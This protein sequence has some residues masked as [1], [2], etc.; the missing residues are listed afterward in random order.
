MAGKRLEGSPSKIIV[1][2]T[3][4]AV[5]GSVNY[6]VLLIVLLFLWP[7]LPPAWHSISGSSR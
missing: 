3:W 6:Q 7:D 2:A 4:L 5:G 1:M